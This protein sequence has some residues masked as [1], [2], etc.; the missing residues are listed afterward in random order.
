MAA[1]RAEPERA[2]AALEELCRAYWYPLYAYA[3]RRR[4]SSHDAEELVQ[5]FLAALLARGDLRRVERSRGRFRS[6]LLASLSHHLARERD[7]ARARKRGGGRRVLSLDRAAAEERFGLEPAH[8]D[9]PERTFE[10]AWA[11]EVLDRA[12]TRLRD[13]YRAAGKERIFEGLQDAL[14]AARGEVDGAR[15]AAELGL[16]DEALRVALHRLRR[17]FREHLRR[18]VAETVRRPEEVEAELAELLRAVS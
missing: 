8:G 2:R 5:S 9:T 11:A 12:L 15:R 10:R 13:E 14:G 18:E 16:S 3:R 4:L 7:R 6:F 17:R 1:A